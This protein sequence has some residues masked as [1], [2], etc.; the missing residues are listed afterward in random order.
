MEPQK[1]STVAA[2]G[3][4]ISTTSAAFSPQSMMQAF[5]TAA[6]LQQGARPPPTTSGPS[7]QQFY[8]PGNPFFATG[9]ATM[10]SAA[11][12]PPPGYLTYPSGASPMDLM[13]AAAQIHANKGTQQ[14]AKD[15]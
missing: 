14:T 1:L 10:P 3:Q 12:Y 8:A 4:Q 5:F 15:S 9:F 6:A 13:A 11:A 7:P 2:P